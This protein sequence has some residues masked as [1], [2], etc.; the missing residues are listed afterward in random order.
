[1][2]KLRI[3]DIEDGSMVYRSKKPCLTLKL[4]VRKLSKMVGF[5][6]HLLA[7][8]PHVTGSHSEPAQKKKKKKKE[9]KEKKPQLWTKG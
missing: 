7:L 1:L 9:K 3:E 2:I 5:Y 8:N 4:E 6:G